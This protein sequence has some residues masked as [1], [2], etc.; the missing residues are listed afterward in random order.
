MKHEQQNKSKAPTVKRTMV[1]TIASGFGVGAIAEIA[2]VVGLPVA[3][4][5]G[6]VGLGLTA[7]GIGA[8][9]DAKE[10][11]EEKNPKPKSTHPFA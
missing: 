9:S 4:A 6:I 8:A 11:E 5:V 10:R 7:I 3:A 2:L 1:R